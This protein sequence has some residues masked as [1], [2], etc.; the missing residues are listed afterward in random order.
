MITQHL[1]I[2]ID[3]ITSIYKILQ[4]NMFPQYE[5]ILSLELAI[6]ISY[7]GFFKSVVKYVI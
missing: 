5:E 4:I 2:L 1:Y 3:K 7:L 6:P